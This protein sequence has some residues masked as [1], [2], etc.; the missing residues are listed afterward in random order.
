MVRFLMSTAVSGF[1]FIK[2]KHL[3]EGGTYSDLF[4]NCAAPIRENT[5]SGEKKLGLFPEIGWIKKFLSLARPQ[6][7]MCIRIYVFIFKKI[8]K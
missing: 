2:A 4:V 6:S 5:I 8:K 1:A 7:R 3:L